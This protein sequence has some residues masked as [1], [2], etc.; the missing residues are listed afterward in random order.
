VGKVLAA[1]VRTVGEPLSIEELTTTPI[2]PTEVRVKTRAVGLCHSDLHVLDGHIER[3]LPHLLGHEAAGV[4]IEV[5]AEV[6]SVAVGDHVVACLVVHC[7]Q[8][9]QCLAGHRSL[10]TNKAVCGRGPDEAP[11]YAGADGEA[12]EQFSNVGAL[13]EEMIVHHS[14]LT[15]VPDE[16]P[17]DMAA[18]LGCAVVTGV[19]AVENVARVRAGEAVVVIGAGGVGLNLLH[20]A[21]EAGA[22]PVVAIDLDDKRRTLALDHF[23]ATHA[24]D[25]ADPD[26]IDK[27]I[28]ATGGGAD[29][30]F[31]V[32]GAPTLTMNCMK[33][34][35]PGGM[36]Y[37][38][39][40]FASGTE[41][42]INTREFH[43]C[44]GLIGIRMGDVNPQVD[45]AELADRYLA[46][47][48]PLDHLV[49]DRIPIEEANAGFERLASVD[50]TRSV[51]VFPE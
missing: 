3:P 18:L 25:G 33:M 20:A 37:T 15:P 46:G 23:G 26:M 9:R 38:V 36:T 29:H 39:G 34:C 17:F 49:S 8:C 5:G 28:E 30:A 11:R 48:L 6:D 42:T 44:K 2:T 27:V 51:V 13:A 12:I 24:F 50:G 35:A 16:L 7:G 14:A 32:V 45:I 22:S 21:A 47:N 40:I 43:Q 31:D 10:C 1:V 19:G 41:L 4:V